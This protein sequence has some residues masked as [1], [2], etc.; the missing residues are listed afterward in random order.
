MRSERQTFPASGDGGWWIV[1]LPD[2][3]LR[4]LPSNEYLTMSWLQRAGFDVP[5]VRLERA[6]SIPDIPE[7]LVDPKEYLYLIDRFDRR[8]EGRVHV[9]DF[10]QV[11]DVP[12]QLKYG[13]SGATYDG[14]AAAVLDVVGAEGYEDFIR[15]LVAMIITG[16]TDAHLKNWAFRY[17]A[18]GRVGL[19]PV[20]DFHSL[21]VYDRFRYAPLALSLNGEVMNGHLSIDDF[22][23]VAEHS[24][25]DPDATVDTVRSAVHDLRS[26]WSASV[27][28]ESERLFP[29]LAKH[30]EQRLVSL[31]IAAAAD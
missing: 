19:A 1:K 2:R 4:D 12:P 15:R 11:A 22:R 25:T 29:A 28:A 18:A 20:Y 23:R 3:S 10:A 8:P 16:N 6:A 24:G 13:D 5:L 7:G 21:T 14:L 30:Y 31:P 26:A 17:D 9:E 27:R